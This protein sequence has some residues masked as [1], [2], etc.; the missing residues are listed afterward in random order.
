MI[1]RILLITLALTT[2]SCSNGISQ[3]TKNKVLEYRN[4]EDEFTIVV[5]KDE[6]SDKEVKEKALERAAMLANKY[7]Y[8]SFDITNKETVE[9]MLG[10]KDW[11]SSYD[12]PQNLYQEE[13]VEKGYNRERFVSG[14]KPDYKVRKAVKFSIKCEKS[15]NEGQYKVCEIID[16]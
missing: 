13:I 5:I 12:Y 8:R 2:I 11:P 9:V 1:V 6:K 16:C 15:E 4:S 3:D 14:S 7:G 10:K